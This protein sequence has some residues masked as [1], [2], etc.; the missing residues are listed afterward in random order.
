MKQTYSKNLK[1]ILLTISKDDIFYIESRLILAESASENSFE[2]EA[3]NILNKLIKTQNNTF[4]IYE[5]LG[6]IYRYNEKF[7]FAEEAY[8]KRNILSSKF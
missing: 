7:E 6:N 3:I 5:L 2:T 8:S 1:E 4:E